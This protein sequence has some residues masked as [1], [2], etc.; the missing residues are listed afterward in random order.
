MDEKMALEILWE[1]TGKYCGFGS[2]NYFLITNLRKLGVDVFFKPHE[3]KENV[4][5]EHK[6]LLDP[7][8]QVEVS[9]DAYR[10]KNNIGLVDYDIFICCPD[11]LRI[12]QEIIEECNNSFEV[13]T[14]SQFCKRNL[15]MAGVDRHIEVIPHGYEPKIYNPK[16]KPLFDFKKF[17]FLTIG[18]DHLPRKDFFGLISA[19]YKEFKE[20]EAQLLIHTGEAAKLTLIE[21]MKRVMPLRKNILFSTKKLTYSEMGRLYNSCDAYVTKTQGEAFY[22]PA[23][24]A[25]ACEL[26][27]IIPYWS[28]YLDFLKDKGFY[29]MV[30][31]LHPMF[32]ECLFARVDEY[33]TRM[34]MRWVYEN[35]D[36]AKN[37]AKV[38]AKELKDWTWENAAK[39]I[40]RRLND[41]EEARM[42]I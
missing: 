15:Y 14:P 24:E 40:I 35:Y 39:I 8:W 27:V 2:V 20:D 37:Q 1:G 41:I 3:G 18:T 38:L 36:Y 30:N 11:S 17:T 16:R 32:K 28:G 13:W 25:A 29:I 7:F 31:G 4:S 26:P 21:E 9:E 6:K 19:F 5:K 42:R 33:H 10:V 34:M 22:L 12:S 23:L